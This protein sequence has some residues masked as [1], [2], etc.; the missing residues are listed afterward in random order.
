MNDIHDA[1]T[2]WAQKARAIKPDVRPWI[3]GRRAETT[4]PGKFHSLNPATGVIVAELPACG[5]FEIDAAVS[6]AR[7]AF[8]RGDWSGLSPRDRAQRLHAFAEAI[9][10]SGPELALLDSL[11]MGMPIGTAVAD[12]ES[13]V[14]QVHATAEAADK[15]IDAVIP[16]DSSALLLNVREPVGVV[17]AITPWNFPAY[18][19]ITKIVPALAVGNS[20]VLK[21]SEVASLSCLRLGEIAAEAGIPDGVI[22]VVPGLGSGAGSALAQHLDVNLLTFTGSTATGKRLLELSG[23]SNMKRLVLECGGKS[24]H[25]VFADTADLDMVADAVVGSIT[26]N[27]G[28]VCVAGSRLLVERPIHDALL[29]KI[30]ERAQGILAGDPLDESTSFGPLASVDQFERVR[31]Y[32]ESGAAEGAG[33]A[34]DG[35]APKGGTGCYWLP[36]V[37]TGVRRE[38]RI[39]REEIFGPILSTLVFDDESEAVAIANSTIYGLIATIWTQDLSRGLRMAKSIRAGSVTIAGRGGAGRMDAT[40]GA[41]EPHGQSGFGIEGGL[42]GLRSFTRLKSITVSG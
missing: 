2:D 26:F 25:I 12:M 32:F 18:I 6:A 34:L 28:Q 40:A 7:R 21:P 19:G 30:V 13:V 35:S 5:Q 4:A 22:N 31:R 10:R 14:A 16:N 17:G 20:V 9:G 38:M 36:T 37:F 1:K 42:E 15:L 23:L 24:P 29:E 11:E 33:L 41:F 27:A 3:G 39:A 8:E